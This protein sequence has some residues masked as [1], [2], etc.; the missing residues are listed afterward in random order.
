[1]ADKMVRITHPDGRDGAILPADFTKSNL[2]AEGMGSYADQGY[3]ID[4]YESGEDFEG[5][6]SLKEMQK[7]DAAK[8]AAREARQASLKAEAKGKD[9]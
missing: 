2:H 3:I 9:S 4:R 5:P 6:K 8:Q 1:M 7:V